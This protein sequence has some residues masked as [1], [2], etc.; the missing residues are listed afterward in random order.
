MANPFLTLIG[1]D[2]LILI[3]IRDSWSMEG[4]YNVAIRTFLAS[5]LIHFR[6]QGIPGYKLM[7]STEAGGAAPSPDNLA[8]QAIRWMLLNK[9]Y[10][11]RCYTYKY[12]MYIY[13][14]Q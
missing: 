4:V 8:F 9:C 5:M 14:Y 7:A 2:W 11:D 12:V 13:I 1:F 3:E 6:L 10:I